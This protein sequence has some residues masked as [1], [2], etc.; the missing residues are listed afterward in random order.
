MT[1][2]ERVLSFLL[3]CDRCAPEHQN[4]K[5]IPRVFLT[6]ITCR[7]ECV[8]SYHTLYNRSVIPLLSVVS[9]LTSIQH[10]PKYHTHTHLN[11]QLFLYTLNSICHCS[12]V[13]RPPDKQQ[14]QQ[15]RSPRLAAFIFGFQPGGL[16]ERRTENKLPSFSF[17][18]PA[19]LTAFLTVSRLAGAYLVR[20]SQV[21]LEEETFGFWESVCYRPDYQ[22]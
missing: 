1:S 13:C 17:R 8:S 11:T 22:L 18:P 4:T 3:F 20:S 7:H 10:P 9:V 6:L 14:Q 15:R 16:S 21:I 5:T 19:L 12:S 2:A